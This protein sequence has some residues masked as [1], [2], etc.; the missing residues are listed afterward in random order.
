MSVRDVS[1]QVQQSRAATAIFLI[2]S[3]S[4]RLPSSSKRE[5]AKFREYNRTPPSR[6]V[7]SRSISPY[8]YFD[9]M[10]VITPSSLRSLASSAHMTLARNCSSLSAT[11]QLHVPPIHARYQS[12]I[13]PRT[14]SFLHAAQ[15]YPRLRQLSTQTTSYTSG[16]IADEVPVVLPTPQNAKGKA[17]AVDGVSGDI[18]GHDVLPSS[19]SASTKVAPR[20]RTLGLKAKKAAITLVC[21]LCP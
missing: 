11:R 3:T 15:R 19:P 8:I 7:A 21:T 9:A 2:P 13:P 17:K 10:S 12:A 4:C 16:P 18:I 14:A 1:V 6:L 5:N 20:R